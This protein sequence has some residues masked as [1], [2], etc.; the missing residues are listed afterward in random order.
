MVLLIFFFFFQ[1]I[2]DDNSKNDFIISK[3]FHDSEVKNCKV[4]SRI[5][6]VKKKERTGKNHFSKTILL[7][8]PAEIEYKNYKINR[9][10]KSRILIINIS[11]DLA[12]YR[13]EKCLDK[14]FFDVKLSTPSGKFERENL[15]PG[16]H[17]ILTV[18]FKANIL[19]NFSEFI[20]LNIENGEPVIINLRAS[21]EPPIL[22][23]KN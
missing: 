16:M 17:A 23:G 21:K 14:T 5:L 3:K 11:N 18:K 7:V 12:K 4:N 20:V 2:E 13:I 10:Y 22:S 19:D 15:A 9:V 6:S 8:K 1:Q